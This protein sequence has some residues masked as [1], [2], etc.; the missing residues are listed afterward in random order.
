LCA[1]TFSE[2]APFN[3]DLPVWLFFSFFFSV[4]CRYYVVASPVFPLPTGLEL[5]WYMAVFLFVTGFFPAFLPLFKGKIL[6]IQ[7][8]YSSTFALV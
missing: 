6:A 4:E 2:E 3:D 7:T 8:N 5:A 1:V